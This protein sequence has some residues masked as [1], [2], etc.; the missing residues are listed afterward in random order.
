MTI[1]NGNLNAS[2]FVDTFKP[3]APKIWLD[4]NGR[5]AVIAGG[6]AVVSVRPEAVVH[7]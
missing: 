3:L 7:D 5:E 1:G 6:R 4:D 2:D